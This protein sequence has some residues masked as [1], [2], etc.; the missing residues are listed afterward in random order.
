MKMVATCRRTAF[1]LIELLVVIAIIACLIALL[2]P[3]IQGVMTKAGTIKCESNLK[4]IGASLIL[5]AND[6]AQRMPVIEPWPSQ[7]L[8]NS[9]D[10]AQT[11]LQALGPYGATEAVL[12]CPADLKGPNYYKQEGSSYQWFPMAKARNP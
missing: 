8:Y 1:T 7:P 6:H 9:A 11:M 4:Q 10:G 5:Y 2:M 12:Q 3:S